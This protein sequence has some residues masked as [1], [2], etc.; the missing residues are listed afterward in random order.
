MAHEEEE[1]ERR[2]V[3]DKGSYGMRDG[4]RC[5]PRKRGLVWRGVFLQEKNLVPFT[6]IFKPHAFLLLGRT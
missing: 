1:F 2:N 3:E 5:A 4:A 6:F